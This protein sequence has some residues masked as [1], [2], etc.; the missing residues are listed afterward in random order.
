MHFIIHN[1]VSDLAHQLGIIFIIQQLLYD[2]KISLDF[3]VTRIILGIKD[4]LKVHNGLVLA[5]RSWRELVARVKGAILIRPTLLTRRSVVEIYGV[6][7][8]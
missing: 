8:L 5:L 7:G 2:V 4:G 1:V 6:C 3:L